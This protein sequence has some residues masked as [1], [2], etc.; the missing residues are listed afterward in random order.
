MAD[1]SVLIKL[2]KHELDE[3]RLFL[4][5]LYQAAADI[6]A[7]RA[8]VL[9]KLAAEKR[10]ADELGG[11]HYTLADYMADA[12][13]KLNIL[14]EREADVEKEIEVAKDDMMETFSDLK[15]YEM[16]QEAREALE[17]QERKLKDGK[18]LDEIGLDGFMRKLAEG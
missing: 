13:V 6:N 2:H 9:A 15:K 12:K 16:T 18:M 17:E 10:A 3:K 4:A 14:A 7:E 1:L 5:K 11:V 8:D